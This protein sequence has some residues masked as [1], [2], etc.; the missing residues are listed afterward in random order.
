MIVPL[1]PERTA[2]ADSA[3]RLLRDRYADL[4]GNAPSELSPAQWREFAELGWLGTAISEAHGGLGLGCAL[5]SVLV[6]S[7]AP[8]AMIE[9]L[10][11]QLALVGQVLNRARPGRARD[12]AL[13]AWMNGDRLLALVHDDGLHG[14][15]GDAP[16]GIRHTDTADGAVLHGCQRGVIDGALADQLL[17][18]AVCADAPWVTRLFLVDRAAVMVRERRAFDGRHFADI[19]IEQLAV[20][21]STRIEFDADIGAALDE[22]SNFHALLLAADSAGLARAL[23]DMTRA[24]LGQREQFGRKLAEFQVLQHRLVDMNLALT[25]LES[26]LELAR[27]KVDELGLTGADAYIAAAKAAAGINGRHIAHEAMQLH[28]AIGLTEELLVG[29]YVRR[30]TANELLGGTTE[31]QLTRFAELRGWTAVRA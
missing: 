12:A 10:T 5:A 7:L 4:T 15:P 14:T 1:S 9:P 21:P 25:R 27:F 11:S 24:Y 28:G 30:L 16:D 20:P 22:A 18:V 8:A 17:V 13:A 3:Q 2:L 23:C 31:T 26:L 6:E 19:A 29:R